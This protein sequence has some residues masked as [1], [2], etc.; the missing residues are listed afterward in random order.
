MA[1]IVE[2]GTIVSGADSYVTRADAIAYAAGRGVTLADTDATDVIL[3]SAAAYL[4][5][6]ADQFVG[7][8]VERDQPMQWPRTG[9][10]I[11]GW[12][13][14]YTEIPRQVVSAQ[15]AVA[16]EVAAGIDPYNPAP[17]SGQVIE[18]SVGGAVTVKYASGSAAAQKV[19]KTRESMTIIRLLINRAG[20]YS[21]R[22]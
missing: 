10:V 21:V 9:V 3:R 14:G 11:E 12:S 15:L 6:F 17:Q 8:L 4:D 20:I 2:D 16:L 5:S 18:K 13:W 22:S 7:V 1:L 19:S